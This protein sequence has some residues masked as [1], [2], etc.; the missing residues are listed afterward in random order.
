MKNRRGDLAFGAVSALAGL[1][2]TFVPNH[3]LGFGLFVFLAWAC[4]IAVISAIVGIRGQRAQLIGAVVSLAA[5]VFAG[6][7]LGSNAVGVFPWIVGGWA[8]A[9]ALGT[10]L[11][12]RGISFL[13]VATGGF[14]IAQLAMPINPV[15]NVGLTGAFQVV[16]AIWLVIG[17]L[18][19][20]TPGH[21]EGA[22]ERHG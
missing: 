8:V 18:S 21:T 16:I 2:I 6:L 9:F 7:A 17:A 4:A 20:N 12:D 14:G 1:V 13:A 5:A 10:V 15:V 22:V 11:A 19:P 3:S